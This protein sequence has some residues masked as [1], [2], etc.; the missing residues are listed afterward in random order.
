M[1]I[2]FALIT[3]VL[4]I[5]VIVN[6]V[7]T[8]Y[9]LNNDMISRIEKLCYLCED[10]RCHLYKSQLFSNDEKICLCCLKK[11][12]DIVFSN[13]LPNKIFVKIF[14]SLNYFIILQAL[15]F[16][17]LLVVS[18]YSTITLFFLINHSQLTISLIILNKKKIYLR[19]AKYRENKLRT[20]NR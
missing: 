16:I 12:M 18:I 14:K 11:E 2:I 9:V 20:T 7:N 1:N 17:L 15:L 4:L 19:Y 13:S 10:D 5:I 8:V 6:T 3:F